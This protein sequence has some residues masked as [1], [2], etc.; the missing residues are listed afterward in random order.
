MVLTIAMLLTLVV[1]PASAAGPQVSVAM[2]ADKTTVQR[3]TVTRR[4]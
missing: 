1:V 3:S 4:F 2:T